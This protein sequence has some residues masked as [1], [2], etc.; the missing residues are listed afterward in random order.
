MRNSGRARPLTP[1]IDQA[2]NGSVMQRFLVSRKPGDH[3]E[4]AGGETGEQ[5]AADAVVG[6][7]EDSALVT[8]LTAARA[9]DVSGSTVT[10]GDTSPLATARRIR[11]IRS[12]VG[13]RSSHA[14]RFGPAGRM[15]EWHD[16]PLSL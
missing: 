1:I 5:V 10:S 13:N 14:Y 11:R 2:G 7:H 15:R 6:D 4:T 3:A 16:C 8:R 12:R 9:S